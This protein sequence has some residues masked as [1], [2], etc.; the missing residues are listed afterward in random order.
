MLTPQQYVPR[1]DSEYSDY[2]VG[3]YAFSAT[4]AI[5]DITGL[6]TSGVSSAHIAKRLEPSTESAAYL[7]A[8]TEQHGPRPVTELGVAELSPFDLDY[9]QAW[10]FVSLPLIEDLRVIEA[11]FTFDSEVAPMPGE[12]A[13]IAPWREGLSLIDVLSTRI[14]RPIRQLWVTHQPGDYTPPA[15]GEFGYRRAFRE[16]QAVFPVAAA[17]GLAWPPGIAGE[18]C[19]AIEYEVVEGP[20]FASRPAGGAGRETEQF[21]RLL[22]AAS[23]NYPRGELALEAIEWDLQRIV[24]AGERLGDRGGAQ[25]TGLARVRG[26]GSGSEGTGA[27]SEIVGLCEVVHYASDDAKVCELGLV[28]VLPEHRGRGIGAGLIRATLERAAHTWESLET[29][30][31][32][33]PAGSAPAEALMRA[34]GA[35]VISSTTAW[36]LGTGAD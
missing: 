11:N 13:P 32:S 16:D 31:C 14:D 2:V 26:A 7:F 12:P 15:V 36:Q 23:K 22:T 9:V 33:Y 27:A 3:G 28:Y 18:T 6:A 25:L 5:Q 20:G 24:D 8:I 35:R 34:L 4:L 30:Y 17:G 21:A 10:V 29:A 19:A 1:P